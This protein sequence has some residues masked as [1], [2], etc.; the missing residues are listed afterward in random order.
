LVSNQVFL[1]YYVRMRKEKETKPIVRFDSQVD[2]GLTKDQVNSRI[3]DKLT[4]KTKSAV[5]KSYFEIIHTNVFSFF[6]ILLFIIAGLM[7]WAEKYDGLFFLAIIIPNMGVGLY[8]D[9][10]ARR[11][12]SKLQLLSQP[13]S[14]VIR[15]GV[16][17]IVTTDELVLDDITELSSEM[18]IC[19]DSILLDGSLSVNES[20]LTGE[21]HS[22]V[23]KPG[24]IVYSG[25]FVV[26]GKGH[27]RV[28]KIGKDSY[29]QTLQDKANK[30]S[31][32]PS[33]ILSSLRRLFLVIGILVIIYAG[34][35]I[36]L[37]HT[38]GNLE[39]IEVFKKKAV[40]SIAGSMV[41]MIPCGLYLL[42]SAAL[43]VSVIKLNKHNARV[44]D[45]YSVEMLAR[46]DVLCVDKT[47][48]ITDGTMEVK[49]FLSFDKFSKD[50]MAQHICN[51]LVAT[52]DMNF[53]ARALRNYFTYEATSVATKVLPFNSENKYSAA[54][55]KG[56]K[57]IV[58]GAI[59]FINFRNKNVLLDKA[60]QYTKYGY[61]VLGIGSL[62]DGEINHNMVIGDVEPMGLIIIKDHIRPDAINTF[63]WFKKNNVSIR[64]ISG[65]SAETTSHVAQE[66]GIEGAEK[67][68]S[69]EGMSVEQV[70]LIANEYVVF[71]RVSPEQKEAIVMA[72]K[73]ANH[74]VAMTGDG[75][76]DIL[77]LKRSDC[78]IAMA[79][80]A[81]AA[82][83]VS[84]IVLSDSNFD[85]LPDVVAQGRRIINNIQRTSSLFL[86]KT[87]FAFFFSTWFLINA[88]IDKVSVF[89]F[90]VNN[91][92]IWEI[93]AYGMPAFFL[94]LEPNNE[95][96][97]GNF[98]RNVLSR[99]IPGA[100]LI[101]LPVAAIYIMKYIDV[102][103][104]IYLGLANDNYETGTG[105]VKSMAA[106]MV[107]IVSFCYLYKACSPFTKY[108][109]LV[110]GVF[111]VGAFCALVGIGAYT[112]ITGQP[113]ILHINFDLLRP[114]N[115]LEMAII[116]AIDIAAYFTYFAVKK[117]VKEGK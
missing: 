58:M 52:E 74:T 107:S 76:N 92:Y 23:K 11:L 12:L 33:I 83:N 88:L 68:I 14:T 13:K 85:H 44:Q 37:H 71:G 103:C 10:K 81:Q 73:E 75:V 28:D 26:S 54:T 30:F 117:A 39:T 95:R 77:A 62:I 78:S 63:K 82:K 20:L 50:D 38:L 66:A 47:G 111:S 97:E 56:G 61:R 29:V 65:D 21:S 49:E 60:S 84:H 94:A 100:L 96:V 53:T 57:T 55:F 115:Y 48:T 80:G 105:V 31:R 19:A 2:K 93:A 101:I 22:I 6:N 104:G 5:G 69:L 35:T 16:T 51:L 42:T 3:A 36:I 70:K 99:V 112:I 45:F 109:K 4:N 67:Y 89:P 106:I 9:I 1:L 87:S 7:I 114:I 72:I 17:Q 110:F 24:D 15:D 40:P 98:F 27:A 46:S 90:D 34:L 43:A 116:V 64:V 8:E 41:T 18:Q 59:E 108:R 25:S 79:S 32:S 91:L 113:N 86:A 102:N